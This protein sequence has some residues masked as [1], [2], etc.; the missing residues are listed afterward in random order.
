MESFG[1]SFLGK[2]YKPFGFP[3]LLVSFSR[4]LNYNLFKTIVKKPM[5]F[6]SQKASKK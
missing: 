1:L 4:L 6:F 2:G 3:F 5:L